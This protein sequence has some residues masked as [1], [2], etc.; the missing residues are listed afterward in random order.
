VL[1]LSLDKAIPFFA[2]AID[3]QIDRDD[4]SDDFIQEKMHANLRS[5][6]DDGGLTH[7]FRHTH[8]VGIR[9]SEVQAL[10]AGK[11]RGETPHNPD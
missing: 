10:G 7:E 2:V 3:A 4:A 5:L 9:A 6:F 1:D 8:L 11:E